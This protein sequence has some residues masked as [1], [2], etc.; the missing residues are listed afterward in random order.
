MPT[1]IGKV[2]LLISTA[3]LMAILVTSF[4]VAQTGRVFD[5]TWSTID[6]GG[7][8]S[9]GGGYSLSGT[10]GQPNAGA[11]NGSA[12]TLAGG[13]W[14]VAGADHDVFLPLVLRQEAN[15]R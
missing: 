3:A 7:G 13:F 11:L 12:Y 14:N 5:L 2:A 10:I 8:S 1:R 15:S 6:G 9:S 4:A